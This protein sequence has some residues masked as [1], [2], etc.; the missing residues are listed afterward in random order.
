MA[1]LN[2]NGL[3]RLNPRDANMKRISTGVVSGI[4]TCLAIPAV[5]AA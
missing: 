4:L 5:H 1:A 2:E 3:A